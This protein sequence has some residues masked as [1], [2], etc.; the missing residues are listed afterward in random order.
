MAAA[1][2][3][4]AVDLGLDILDALGIRLQPGNIDLNIEVANV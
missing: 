4:E 2:H 3:E 1:G